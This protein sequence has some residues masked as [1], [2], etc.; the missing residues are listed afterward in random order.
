[1][2]PHDHDIQYRPYQ[3]MKII[4]AMLLFFSLFLCVCG[5]FAGVS[6]AL[7]CAAVGTVCFLV[8]K[9]LYDQSH[10]TV[11]LRENELLVFEKTYIRID[12]Q[13]IKHAFYGRTYKGQSFWL[14]SP[15]PLDRRQFWKFTNRCKIH[16]SDELGNTVIVLWMPLSRDAAVMETLL[17]SKI[18]NIHKDEPIVKE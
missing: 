5:G 6:G 3:S 8:A 15:A 18:P 4:A 1:M 16:Q 11:V 17:R 14:L 7:P 12:W 2:E 13:E 9:Y 10:S